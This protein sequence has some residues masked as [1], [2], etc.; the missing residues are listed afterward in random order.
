LDTTFLPWAFYSRRSPPPKNEAQQRD[1]VELTGIV[2]I[3]LT[4]RPKIFALEILRGDFNRARLRSG[5]FAS[6]WDNPLRL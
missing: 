5:L 2:S 1:P 3:D 4:G 6:S